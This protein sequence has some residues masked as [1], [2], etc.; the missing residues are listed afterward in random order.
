[1]DPKRY[2]LLGIDFLGGAGESSGLSDLATEV[3][4][5]T[6][7]DQARA[8]HA[9][10]RG[11][12]L[13]QINAWVGA[14]FGGMVGLAFADLYPHAVHQ[15]IAVSASNRATASA[16]SLRWIQQ[17]IVK[18]AR[19]AGYEQKGVVLARALAMTTYRT[20]REFN[21]R[22]NSADVSDDLASVASYLQ[23]C[24][25]RFAERFSGD[26]FVALSNAIDRHFVDPKSLRVPVALVSVREDQLVPSDQMT[27]FAHQAAC[28]VTVFEFSSRY[29]HDAFLKEPE[30]INAILRQ[31]LQPHVKRCFRGV[32]TWRNH[33]S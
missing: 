4:Y 19:D 21:Q 20:Q 11:L 16:L 5:L 12:G 6:S 26:S 1:M 31:V 7:H 14:S 25:E 29:G 8:L 3:P 17:S 13:S 15:V 28:P 10:W 27:H 33:E 30:T 24:G 2:R 9:V 22:F 32:R 23:H 18:L